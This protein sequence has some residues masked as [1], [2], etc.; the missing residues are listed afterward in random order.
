MVSQTSLIL[1]QE[2][3]VVPCIC[4]SLAIG[5][6]LEARVEECNTP[7]EATPIRGR[8]FSEKGAVAT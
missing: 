1:R 7:G 4:R 3:W 5:C 2:G 8:Q 6:F